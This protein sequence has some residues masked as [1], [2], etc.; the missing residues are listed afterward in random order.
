[1]QYCL[2]SHSL[3]VVVDQGII[4]RSVQHLFDLKCKMEQSGWSISLEAS[5]LEIYNETL[6]D[7][8][9]DEPAGKLDVKHARDGSVSVANLSLHPVESESDIVEL[10]RIAQ[11]NRSVASTK[12][13]EVSSRSHSVFQ[14]RVH[15]RHGEETRSSSLVLVDLAGSERIVQSG[16]KDVQLKEAQVCSFRLHHTEWKCSL[17][18]PLGDQ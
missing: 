2:D 11:T 7:L 6:R 5:Q 3:S 4:P 17:L 13:N 9:T 12:C 16:A 15:A 1:M 8:L 10:L 14:L 18:P